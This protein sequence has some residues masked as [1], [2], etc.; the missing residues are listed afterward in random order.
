[1]VHKARSKC[2]YLCYILYLN[3]SIMDESAC[4]SSSVSGFSDA[5]TQFLTKVG[6]AFPSFLMLGHF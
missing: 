1:V 3:N 2:S 5:R 6:N 4:C